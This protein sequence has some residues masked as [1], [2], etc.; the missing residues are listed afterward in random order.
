MKLIYTFSVESLEEL[1]GQE[2]S[3]AF[4]AQGDK[5]RNVELK[6]V[7]T[8]RIVDRIE[9]SFAGC[10]AFLTPDGYVVCEED[11]SA[12]A[13]RFATLAANI[14][15]FPLGQGKLTNVS[16]ALDYPTFVAE[17]AAEEDFLRAGKFPVG[18]SL[19]LKWNVRARFD[20]SK[21]ER[22]K[23][24]ATPLAIYCDAMRVES[25][26]LRY[27]ELFRAIE[28]AF[29]FRPVPP[30][31]KPESRDTWAARLSGQFQRIGVNITPG[32]L[33]ELRELRDRCSHKDD[34]WWKQSGITTADKDALNEVIQALEYIRGLAQAAVER[35]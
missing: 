21:I 29:P 3:I 6:L 22:L 26:I 17:T 13:Y 7:A 5:G 20:A 35:V 19:E 31:K 1:D 4:S 8:D 32:K 9:V 18:K 14:L 12:D 24:Q 11:L 28:A 23:S 16:D 27:R 34:L 2:N 30:D 33:L 10:S 25:P 15:Q